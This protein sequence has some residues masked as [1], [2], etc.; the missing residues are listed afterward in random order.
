MIQRERSVTW[1]APFG[2]RTPTA[3][4]GAKTSIL[5][6]LVPLLWLLSLNLAGCG[7]VKGIFKAGVWFGVLSVC[8]V[9]GLIVYGA[10]RLGRRS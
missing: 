6:P 9:L 4:R 7:V 10:S 5:S 2:W 8:V 1:R 3:W